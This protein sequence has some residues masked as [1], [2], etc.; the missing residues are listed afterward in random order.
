[1]SRRSNVDTNDWA[2]CEVLVGESCAPI[3]RRLDHGQR[4]P[5]QDGEA[6]E[7]GSPRF[8]PVAD[9]RGR[10]EQQKGQR[11]FGPRKPRRQAR[12]VLGEHLGLHA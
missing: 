10:P 1:M 11:S 6:D 5:D 9:Q 12:M 8:V 3:C 4:R 7:K 2:T